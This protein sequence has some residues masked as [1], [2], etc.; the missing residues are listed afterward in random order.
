MAWVGL[1]VAWGRVPGNHQG[2]MNS[3]NPVNEDSD[4]AP[5]CRVG[6]GLRKGVMASASTFVWQKLFLQL[7]FWCQTIQLLPICPRCLFSCCSSVGTQSESV[8]VSLC[9]GP[10]KGTAWDSKSP[11][12]PSATI[13][14]V[15]TARN[16]G[17]FSSW[18][19]NPGLGCLVWV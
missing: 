5:T 11:P 1:Q 4:M 16:Y 7:S 3:V 18:L 13:P 9:I 10:L 17:D 15:F 2:G 19:W 14:L 8:Q 12:S 6:R